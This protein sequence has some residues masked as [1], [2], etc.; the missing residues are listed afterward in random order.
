[1]SKLISIL[2]PAHNEADNIRPLADRL[3]SIAASLPS[4]RFEYLFINDGSIDATE[5]ELEILVKK[6]PEVKVLELSRNFGKEVAT[7]A[8]L[9][10]AEG[11]AVIMLDADMQHPPEYIPAFIEAWEAGSEV[12]I[13][14][15][16]QSGKQGKLKHWGSELFYAIMNRISDTSFVPRSTDF[17][18]LDRKVVVA[19]RQFTERNR[20]TRGLIDWLGFKRAFVSFDA[21]K[22]LHGTAAYSLPKLWKLALSSFVSH[23]LFPLKVAG[24]LGGLITGVFGTLG[25]FVFIVRYVFN[26]PW[27][28]HFSGPAQLAIIN[29]FLIGIVLMCLGLIALY[30]GNIHEEV[31][32][33][34]MYVVRA[35]R[36]V[37]INSAHSAATTTQSKLPGSSYPS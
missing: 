23:S 34:P 36:N 13:G 30:V 6:A 5:Q 26:D 12:V 9:H 24:Y 33:R 3:F 37:D 4:Y 25:L 14:V 35:T 11:D 8:G 17:R 27:G 32:N 18:L 7:S 16:T 28:F 1:M 29:V 15:R 19:F 10:H 21:P 2:I 22:R 31:A 20:I